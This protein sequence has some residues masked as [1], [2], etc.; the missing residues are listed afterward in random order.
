MSTKTRTIKASCLHGV[1]DLRIVDRVLEAPKADEVQV[2]IT[3]TG[4]CGSDQH[5]FNNFANGDIKILEPLSPGHESSGTVIDVGADVNSLKVGDRVAL[6]VGRPCEECQLCLEGRYN[7]CSKMS[8][9]SSAK[10]FPH[11]QGTLQEAINAQAKWCYKLPGSVT[12]ELGA[13]IEPLSVAIHGARRAALPA[14]ASALVIGAGAVGL[15][16]AAVLRVT[17]VENIVICDIV[18]Q[19]VQ[20]ALNNSFADHGFTVPLKR[21]STIDEK[22]AIAR[23]VAELSKD[24]SAEESFTGFDGVF[25]CTGVEACMQAGIYASRPGGKVIIVG[26]GTPIQTLPISAAALREV[27][28]VGV[29]RYANTYE[30][31]IKMLSGETGSCGRSLPDLSKLVTHRFSGLHAVPNAFAIAGQGVDSEGNLVLKV[32]INTE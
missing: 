2:K 30:Y 29:F 3:S 25:E 19:R 13:L 26:M 14:G 32:M 16:T 15:L 12:P 1:K 18:E 27:D 31:A 10:S 9:R 7:I 20:F 28:L 21:G 5:Y 8:F 11:Y 6:E 4:L 23:E 24:A 22:L 17:G